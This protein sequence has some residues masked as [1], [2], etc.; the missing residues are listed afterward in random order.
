MA[1]GNCRTKAKNMIHHNKPRAANPRA[2]RPPGL[3]AASRDSAI[4]T[5]TSSVYGALGGTSGPS[6]LSSS[7]R[8]FS[9]PPLDRQSVAEVERRRS[10][11]ILPDVSPPN[12]ALASSFSDLAGMGMVFPDVGFVSLQGPETDGTL[13]QNH[14]T[15]PTLQLQQAPFPH[16]SGGPI[17]DGWTIQSGRNPEIFAPQQHEPGEQSES[18]H[19]PIQIVPQHPENCTTRFRYDGQPNNS[20]TCTLE[21]GTFPPP[22]MGPDGTYPAEDPAGSGGNYF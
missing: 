1:L 6:P 12:D 4:G 17:L 7:F 21:G 18:H 10:D 2:K 11:A 14:G 19:R 22:E 20:Y 8:P 16:Y 15:H 9:Q 3:L 13:S 5:D